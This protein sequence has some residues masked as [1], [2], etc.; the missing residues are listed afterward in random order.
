M[1]RLEPRQGKVHVQVRYSPFAARASDD[2]CR[3]S[4]NSPNSLDDR[5]DRITVV[6]LMTPEG[7]PSWAQDPRILQELQSSFVVPQD[8]RIGTYDSY[9]DG[10]HKNN[11]TFLKDLAESGHVTGE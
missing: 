9:G 1:A 7:V 2:S 10:W 11:L 5:H 4:G 6:L 3:L 8:V